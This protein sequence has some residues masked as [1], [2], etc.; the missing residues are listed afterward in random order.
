MRL[1]TEAGVRNYSIF[2]KDDQ[3]FGYF[4]YHGED[5]ATDAAK[6][7]A[8]PKTQEWW[9]IHNPMQTPLASRNEDDWWA[10]AEEVFH[11]G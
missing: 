2:Q 4:E 1:L 7:A 6:M 11:T 9:A 5:W 8:D 3:L 10:M